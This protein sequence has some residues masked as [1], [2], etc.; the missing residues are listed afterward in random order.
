MEMFYYL[1]LPLQSDK[2]L[3]AAFYNNWYEGDANYRK[4]LL[5]FI[6]SSCESRVLRTYKFTPI[7]MATYM[8][9]RIRNMSSL[10]LLDKFCIYRS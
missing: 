7:S 2:L 3:P 4:M 5:F 1:L 8:A 10:Y 6:M 9:V